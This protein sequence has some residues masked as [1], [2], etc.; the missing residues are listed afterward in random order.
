MP[1]AV[2]RVPCGFARRQGRRTVATPVATRPARRFG[3]RVRVMAIVTDDLERREVTY[4]FTGT[5]EPAP[6]EVTRI[7]GASY[8]LLA[9]FG[10]SYPL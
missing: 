6:E 3:F 9:N 1:C 7:L 8:A 5:G 2:A 4:R 10:A